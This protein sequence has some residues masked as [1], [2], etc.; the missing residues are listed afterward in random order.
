MNTKTLQQILEDWKKRS[1]E[2]EKDHD[3]RAHKPDEFTYSH[4]ECDALD[5]CIQDL[6]SF[7]QHSLIG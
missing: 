5:R 7:M 6:E 1:V 2:L 3:F 4:G